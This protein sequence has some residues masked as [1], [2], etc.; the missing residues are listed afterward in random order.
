MSALTRMPSSAQAPVGLD[1]EEHVRRLGLPV[2][3]PRVVRA[4]GEVEV[5]E[6]HRRHQVRG[7]ADRDDP[8][9]VRG[10]ERAV[11][12]RGERE[13][14]EMVGRELELPALRRRPHMLMSVAE[15]G[16]DVFAD[17]RSRSPPP[18]R[19]SSTTRA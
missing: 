19:C 17:T 16:S 3:E 14:A 8:R 15:S 6:D 9:A 12:P 11:Q 5:V 1:R 2:G 7:R 4:E 18:S 13:V 10:R